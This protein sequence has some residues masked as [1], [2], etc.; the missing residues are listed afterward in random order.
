MSGKP[1]QRLPHSCGTRTGLQVFVQED[2]SVDGWCF[3]CEKHVPNPYGEPKKR[4]DLKIKVKTPEEIAEEIAMV[5]DN[6]PY[7][8]YPKRKLSQKVLEYYGVK[9]GLSEED[10]T[11]P[12]LIY[13]P[14]RKQGE[15]TGYKAELLCE[16]GGNKRFT[17]G[18]VKGCDL[19]GWKEAVA[20]GSKRLYITE[21]EKDACSLKSVLEKEAKPEYKGLAAVTSLTKGAGNAKA[22]I[23]RMLP[24]IKRHFK[25]VVLVFDEDEAGKRAEEDVC[26]ILPTAMVASLPEKDA[27]ECVLQGRE[28]ALYK[29]AVFGASIPKNTRLVFGE[30]LHEAAR[31]QAQWGEITTPWDHVNQ[32]TRNIR[33]G[34]TWY[35][36]AG[37]DFCV[38]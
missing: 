29:A 20:T 36:G 11:T 1:I 30:D 35:W 38:I 4:E 16:A 22:D 33:I 10:G 12:Q 21:G 27:N 17:I 26:A 25:E 15:I 7:M 13:F 6:L 28:K 9:T 5:R 23:A 18:D 37:V 24:E 34:E 19:F 14:Y 32:T 31:E 2:G 8:A 3:A